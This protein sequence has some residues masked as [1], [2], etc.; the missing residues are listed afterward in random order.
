MDNYEGIL[1]LKTLNDF[2]PYAD[3]CVTI[4]QLRDRFDLWEVRFGY[5]NSLEQ[6][7]KNERKEIIEGILTLSTDRT[8]LLV[9]DTDGELVWC[10]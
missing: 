10:A 3:C 1:E 7:Y 2:K 9:K 8:E 4:V 5:L 6:F